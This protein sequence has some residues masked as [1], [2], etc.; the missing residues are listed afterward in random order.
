M[1]DE[2]DLLGDFQLDLTDTERKCEGV[3]RL[4]CVLHQSHFCQEPF[5]NYLLDQVFFYMRTW[6]GVSVDNFRNQMPKISLTHDR[7]WSRVAMMVMDCLCLF[8]HSFKFI[9]VGFI[10]LRTDQRNPLYE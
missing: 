6:V 10:R 9:P 5:E 3:S 2:V 8:I 1:E 4:Q 7:N